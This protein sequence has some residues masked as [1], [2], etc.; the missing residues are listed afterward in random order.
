MSL[1]TVILIATALF[2]AAAWL[3]CEFGVRRI[4]RRREND[5]LEG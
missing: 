1:W 5:R 4:S 3:A 2:F